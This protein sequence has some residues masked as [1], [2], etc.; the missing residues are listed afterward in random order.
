MHL[1]R[2]TQTSVATSE[3]N[4]PPRSI[5]EALRAV[6]ERVGTHV[7]DGSAFDGLRAHVRFLCELARH[8]NIPPERLV[9]ELKHTLNGLPGLN[10]L[11]PA[12]RDELH[13]KVVGF[14]IHAYFA[15]AE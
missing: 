11:T 9:V 7:S 10:A 3:V 14:A 4:L 13:S 1:W 2:R 5:E 8:D 15:D 6:R 12:R